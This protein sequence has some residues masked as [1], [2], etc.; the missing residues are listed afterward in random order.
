MHRRGLNAGCY[1]ASADLKECS[2]LQF[3]IVWLA[4]S[5]YSHFSSQETKVAPHFLHQAELPL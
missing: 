1:L 5:V 3:W 2:R 4:H